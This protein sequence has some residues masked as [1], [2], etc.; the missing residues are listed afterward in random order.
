M[1]AQS[2]LDQSRFT[3]VLRSDCNCFSTTLFDLRC[4]NV[5]VYTEPWVHL[6]NITTTVL[7][8]GASFK[9]YTALK[10]RCIEMLSCVVQCVGG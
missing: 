4:V 10:A 2:I 1:C 7:V 5:V 9:R 6:G 8:L 3:L